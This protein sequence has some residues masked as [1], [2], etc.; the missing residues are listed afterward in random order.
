MEGEKGKKFNFRTIGIIVGILV[1]L[2]SIVWVTVVNWFDKDTSN[3][4]TWVG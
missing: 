2:I 1:V 4:V 3:D